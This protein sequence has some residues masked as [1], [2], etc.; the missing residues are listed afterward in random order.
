MFDEAAEKERY[1]KWLVIYNKK[2]EEAKRKAY[3][4][5]P[6]YKLKQRKMFA[7][8]L[9]RNMKNAFK[10]QMSKTPLEMFHGIERNS[11][12]GNSFED[13]NGQDVSASE[14]IPEFDE[15]IKTEHIQIESD[16]AKST[17]MLNQGSSIDM[18]DE[19]MEKF[20]KEHPNDPELGSPL[21]VKDNMSVSEIIKFNNK[22]LKVIEYNNKY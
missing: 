12:D 7:K 5:S 13:Q 18:N 6:E 16:K 17:L 4:N 19:I 21:K 1:R 2:M 10:E 9:K 14:P 20:I 8:L 11:D 22:M 15:G 3:L